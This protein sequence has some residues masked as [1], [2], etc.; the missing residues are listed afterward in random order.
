MQQSIKQIDEFLKD[1]PELVKDNPES[2]TPESYD[3][4]QQEMLQNEQFSG[5]NG[6]IE[7]LVTYIA[8]LTALTPGDSTTRLVAEQACIFALHEKIDAKL[9]ASN[10]LNPDA[11]HQTS[12]SASATP[13]CTPPKD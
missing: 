13:T 5:K 4:M 7:R 3:K 10:P 1:H 2:L 12:A 11:E 9:T 6:V 8:S